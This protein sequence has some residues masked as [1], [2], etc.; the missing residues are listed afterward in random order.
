MQLMKQALQTPKPPRLN[1]F[2]Q[3][4]FSITLFLTRHIALLLLAYC[5]LR[6]IFLFLALQDC[7]NFIVFS[8]FFSFLLLFSN[9]LFSHLLCFLI[10]AVKQGAIKRTQGTC[11]TFQSVSV[12]SANVP[13]TYY[14]HRHIQKIT[15]F[16]I[17]NFYHF[18]INMSE[19]TNILKSS[20]RTPTSFVHPRKIVSSFY[21]YS[22]LSLQQIVFA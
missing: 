1:K 16:C 19:R 4:L 8:I 7:S 13:C 2:L 20:E 11:S 15:L 5:F 10:Y 9:C 6:L 21:I 22:P 18:S 17:V 3:L 14:V 12:F